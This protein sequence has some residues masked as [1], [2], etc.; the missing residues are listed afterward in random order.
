MIFVTDVTLPHVIWVMYFLCR[1]L[2]IIGNKNFCN[3]WGPQ[4]SDSDSKQLDIL[5]FT[6]LLARGRILFLSKST[7]PPI[8]SLWLVILLLTLLRA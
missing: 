6:S 7:K 2:Q 8:T 3:V 4:S 5:A 1:V